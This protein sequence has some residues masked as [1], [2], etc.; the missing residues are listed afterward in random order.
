MTSWFST[1]ELVGAHDTRA[2]VTGHA[3]E[4]RALAREC[5][6]IAESVPGE[7]KLAEIGEDRFGIAEN[8]ADPPR[9]SGI[10]DEIPLTRRRW[11]TIGAQEA[12]P[13]LWAGRERP[14]VLARG[15]RSFRSARFHSASSRNGSIDRPRAIRARPIQRRRSALARSARL[16]FLRA[17]F[18][19][20]LA[21]SRSLAL[22]PRVHPSP[23][24]VRGA[25][26]SSSSSSRGP[27][28]PPPPPSWKGQLALPPALPCRRSF[29]P[30][31]P[32]RS[33][34]IRGRRKSAAF[35][36]MYEVNRKA[37]HRCVHT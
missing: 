28:S 36:L 22:S 19:R 35:T 11:Q 27:L 13:D 17:R 9:R 15:E 1:G 16:A 37:R 10:V 5:R 18:P 20:P 21:L 33:F 3:V 7:R 6:R 8:R 4:I 2:E 30:C 32:P 25:S 12:G 34:A 29:S 14:R 26:S 23:R 24:P 31:L